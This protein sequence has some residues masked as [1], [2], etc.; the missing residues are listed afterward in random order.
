MPGVEILIKT[1]L[2]VSTGDPLVV[3]GVSW[4][5]VDHVELACGEENRAQVSVPLVDHQ[6]H[7]ADHGGE[8]FFLQLSSM[9]PSIPYA[10]CHRRHL[11]TMIR[12]LELLHWIL[13]K[14]A[15]KIQRP[16]LYWQA[17]P[18]QPPSEPSSSPPDNC[19]GE[20]CSRCR[21]TYNVKIT[22]QS[23]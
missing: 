10:W 1:M 19:C 5:K 15:K 21:I 13:W 16:N 17:P 9:T 4:G 7:H 22:K 6:A 23:K 2:V 14:W 8:A 20:S 11:L 3:E 12:R 18:S